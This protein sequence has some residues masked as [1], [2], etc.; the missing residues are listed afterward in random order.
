MVVTDSIYN[1][2]WSVRIYCVYSRRMARELMPELRKSVL[3]KAYSRFK[4]VAE[5]E[6]YVK[7][8]AAQLAQPLVD[9]IVRNNP[10]MPGNLA[11]K[12]VLNVA[13]KATASLAEIERQ[14]KKA[15]RPK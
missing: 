7:C 14:A 8:R 15:K 3:T 11:N 4:S 9:S 6:A 10:R 12:L 13:T 5:R 2:Y 1:R